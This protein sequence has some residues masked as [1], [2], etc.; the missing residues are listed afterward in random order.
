MAQTQCI[1]Q[2][3]E[4]MDSN[5]FAFSLYHHL[6]KDSDGRN[7][8]YSPFSVSSAMSMLLLGSAN[9]SEA[10]L[11]KVLSLEG[12]ENPQ[13]QI[14]KRRVSISQVVE[15][16]ELNTANKLFPEK[17]YKINPEYLAQ[18]KD[19]YDTDVEL[20]DFIQNSDA[21]RKIINDWVSRVTKDKIND[22]LQPGSIS[23]DTR[24]VLANAIYFKG[25]WQEQFK[26]ERTTEQDFH[27]SEQKVGKVNLMTKKAKYNFAFDENLKVQLLEIPYK[28]DTTSMVIALPTDRFGLKDLEEKLTASKLSEMEKKFFKEE[29]VLSLPKFKI[30]YG[31]D[32][33]EAFKNL[34]ANTIFGSDADFSKISDQKDL[35][36]S[37]I[38]H[39]AFVEVNEEG[40]EAA[41]ATAVVMTRMALLPPHQFICDHPFMFFIKHKPTNTILFIGRY[42]DPES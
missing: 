10:E 3:S 23:P 38:A 12:V 20:L 5:N 41:A 19:V 4:N 8:F 33:I 6:L 14:K 18:V 16:L 37:A 30:E 36:V 40:T 7:V 27:I 9:K 34:G 28:G 24:L 13:E 22:L 35:Y 42:V 29:I 11:I 26:K 25:N 17:S 2:S 15:G 32:L 21:S 1:N 39:K 31:S